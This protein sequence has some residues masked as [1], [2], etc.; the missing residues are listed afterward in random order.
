MPEKNIVKSSNRA[1]VGLDY[2]FSDVKYLKG[3]G[4]KKAEVL[5]KCGIFTVLDLFYY[6]PRKYLDRTLISTINDIAPGMSVTILGTVAA[7]GMTRGRKLRFVVMLEDRTGSL[8]LVWFSGYKYLEQAFEIGD[9]LFVSGTIREYGR[10][11]LPHPE[12]EIVGSSEDETIHSGRIIPIYPENSLLKNMGLH[13][14]GLR[15]IIKPALDRL[16]ESPCETIPEKWRREYGLPDLTRSISQVHFPET[17]EAADSGRQRLA[18][19]EL[20][21]LELIMA[22]R[23][24]KRREKANGI[25]LLPPKINGRKLLNNLGFKLTKAQ[26]KVLNEIY[27]DMGAKYQ[28]SRLVQGDVGSGKTIVAVLAILGAIESGYQAALMAPT[29]ILAEQHYYL[30]NELLAP[31]GIETVL[32]DQF[33]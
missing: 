15:R 14:R 20:F 5:N 18:F 26:I 6:V 11:Y 30:I 2:L 19:E 32:S 27:A 4:P 17:Y 12:F 21:Y 28:M 29:E 25:V 24:K 22:G 10:L 13:S 9:I 1:P 8:E 31:L 16:A 33:D 23:H 3:V 7:F